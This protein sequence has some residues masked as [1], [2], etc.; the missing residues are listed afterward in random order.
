MLI[1]ILHFDIADILE[2]WPFM[3]RAS[4]QGEVGGEFGVELF[5]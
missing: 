5:I 4:E 2:V 3:N 1:N